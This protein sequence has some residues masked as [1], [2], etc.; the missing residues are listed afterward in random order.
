MKNIVLVGFMGSGKTTV[1]ELLSEKTGMPLV[2][3]DSLIEQRAGKTIN[4]IFAEEGETHFGKVGAFFGVPGLLMLLFLVG[5]NLSANLFDTTGVL[6][7][8]TVCA[9]ARIRRFDRDT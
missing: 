6:F 3:M 2:D 9:L 4:E 5:A 8:K 1:G 7:P